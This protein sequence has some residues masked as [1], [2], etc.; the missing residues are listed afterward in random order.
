MYNNICKNKSILSTQ[1]V[2]QQKILLNVEKYLSSY[3]SSLLSLLDKRLVGT[4]YD[5]FVSILLNRDSKKGL[6]LSELG[7]YICGT[8]HAPAGTK[9]ISNLL[10]SKNWN[11]D[12][13]EKVQL[14]KAKDYVLEQTQL[15]KFLLAYW[16]DSSIEKPESWFTR[17]LC[18]V[19]SSKA[20]RLTRIK[21][22]YYDKPKGRICVPGYEW[23][24]MMIGGI[25]LTPIVG[26]MRWWT[27]KGIHK[28]QKCN[29]LWRM[30]KTTHESFGS[31]LTHVFDRGFANANILEMLFRFK[32]HFIIRWKHNLLLNL[33]SGETKNTWKI[34]FGKKSMGQ[35]TL[36]DKERKKYF[37]AQIYY[38][39]VIHPE[40]PEQTLYLVVVRNKS[41]DQLSPM[42]LMTDVTIE[43]VKNAWK[44]FFA[45]I[46]RWDIEQAFRFNKAELGLEAIRLWDF[47]NRVK[48][49]FIVLLVYDFLLQFWLKSPDTAWVFIHRF[50][51]RSDKRLLNVRLPLYRLR[52]A[53][54]AALVIL[55]AK[56][57]G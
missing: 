18:A 22:G 16:D 57:S 41:V 14:E 12:V 6:L 21:P 20:S 46:R 38:Q 50:C 2:Q 53:L 25:H 39:A 28:E 19:F 31:S 35:K 40:F 34:A 54:S 42:Y 23:T 33:E 49:M 11:S 13:L 30:M 7:K 4:F 15:G 51:K 27:T 44:I 26:L 17:G 47:E 36:W 10:R 55:W 52:A 45:Y 32:Q 3:L 9:R 24:G 48:F 1:P 43:N 5:L 56:N 29:I 8:A 37:R